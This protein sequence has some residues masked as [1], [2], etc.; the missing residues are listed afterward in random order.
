M[1]CPVCESQHHSVVATKKGYDIHRCPDCGLLF[2]HPFPSAAE[3]SDFYSNY[4]KSKQYGDKMASKIKRARKRIHALGR[5]A[6]LTLLDV[7]CNLGF[8]T[9]AARSLGYRATGIDVDKVAVERACSTFPECGFQAVSI[10]EL[11]ANGEKFD[12]VYCSEVIEHLV[13]PLDFLK[14]IRSVMK[15]DSILL[16]TTPDVGHYSLS[17]NINKLVGWT[18]FRPPEHLLYFDRRS[19][20]RLFERA[21][22]RKIGFKFSLKPTLKIIASI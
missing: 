19:L 11:A 22:F 3:L 7:G 6:G 16:M 8:A 9:E 18:T 15:E 17:K 10:G 4:H 13:D 21:G 14:N 2:I 1:N 20:G 12:T 5:P